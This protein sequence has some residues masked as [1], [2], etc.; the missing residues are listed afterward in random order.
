MPIPDSRPLTTTSYAILTLLAVQPWTPYELARQLDR[1]MQWL[2]S[3]SASVVYE[4]PKRLVQ[5]GFATAEQSWTGRRARTHYAITP[6]GRDRLAE[7]LARRNPEPDTRESDLLRVACADQGELAD[8]RGTLAA[9]RADAEDRRAKVLARVDEYREDGGPFPDRLPVISLITRLF[10]EQAE[11][12]ARWAAWA[13]TE[14]ETWQ[15]VTPTTGARLPDLA[16]DPD[17]PLP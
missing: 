9:L 17:R 3:R 16:F 4:E 6:A 15:G 8:L 12:A 1:S 13:E 14:V 2:S 10:L 5:A 7:W 11:A